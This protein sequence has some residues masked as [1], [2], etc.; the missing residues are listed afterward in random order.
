[1]SDVKRVLVLGCGS[2]GERHI[3]CMTAV[4]GD[5]VEIIACDTRQERLDAMTEL[6]GVADTAISY[7]DADLSDVDAVMV[8]TPTHLHIDPAM[9]AAEAGCH[10][11]VEK[12][13]S[14]TL[15]G[16]SELV[17]L[18]RDRELILQMGYVMRHHPNL[19]EI[20]AL[21]DIGKIGEVNMAQIKSGY[22]IGKYRPE[23]SQLYWAHAA[24]G[25]G[26]IWDASHQ[27][28]WIQWLLGPITHVAAMRA[29]FMLDI[30][31][32][33]EDSAVMML[34]FAGGAMG[35]VSLSNCQQNY[36]G[37]VELNGTK[38]SIEW[39]Y[40]D[41]EVRIYTEDDKSWRSHS[42]E[43]ERDVFFTNQASNFLGALRGE[44]RPA[45]VG[46]DGLRALMVSLAAYES[47]ETGK[48]VEIDPCCGCSL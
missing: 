47:C 44:E 19:K 32:D 2:I 29:H 43:Y 1:M 17:K 6:Y 3:R 21:L 8:C 41:S 39:S 48:V 27:Q 10:L 26:V 20:K 40:G 31:E 22:F 4:G 38:G 35:S 13:I 11:F 46:E 33:V 9:R 18:C 37:G 5:G 16:V 45:V 12:P 30:D 23:Y 36:K 25:G 15:D 42:A 28:D 7:D 34:R 14:N 24:T